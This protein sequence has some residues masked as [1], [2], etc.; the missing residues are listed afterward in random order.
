MKL[1]ITFLTWFWSLLFPREEERPVPAPSQGLPT[2]FVRVTPPVSFE[3]SA[4]M[5]AP[6]A[7]HRLSPLDNPLIWQRSPAYEPIGEARDVDVS[8]VQRQINDIWGTTADRGSGDTDIFKLAW[9]GDRSFWFEIFMEWYGNGKPSAPAV[10]RPRYKYGSIYGP[11][12]KFIRDTFPPRWILL[13][14]LEPEQYATR[15]YEESYFFDPGFRAWKQVRPDNP[16]PVYWLN[17]AIVA[18][19][20]NGCCARNRR[21]FGEYAHPETLLE[22]LAGEKKTTDAQG[23]RKPFEKVDAEDIRM[24]N[25]AANGYRYEMKSLQIEAEIMTANPMA[26]IGL[27]GAVATDATYQKAKQRVK[28][29]YDRQIDELADN[30]AKGRPLE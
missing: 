16:P 11:H 21:C 13:T 24:L 4:P 10:L 28:D 14:R 25:D 9:N 12:K 22:T 3:T 23:Q 19:H 1:I 2:E 15:W 7:I 29:F 20:R 30:A 27:Q 17:Y 26:A 5:F 8:A 6:P 18:T